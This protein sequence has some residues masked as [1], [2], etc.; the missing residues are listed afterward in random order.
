M[1]F[2]DIIILD[3]I[4]T[5][6]PIISTLI[7]KAHL[8]NQNKLSNPMFIDI[9]NIS[10]LFLLIKYCDYGNAYMVLLVNIPFII[11]VLY[12]RKISSI[13][14]LVAL[15]V[16][17]THVGLNPKLLI[18]EYAV[19]LIIFI[20]LHKKKT[21]A[22]NILLSFVSIKGFFLTIHEYYT[23]NN[24]NILT[25]IQIFICLIVFYGIVILIINII[26][27]VNNT[28]G[29]N[30]SLK[31]LEKEKELKNALFKI[32]HEVKNPI[33]VCKG[34]L[35]MMEYNDLKKV[36]KYN[37]II[38]SELN[39]T[40]DI[41]DKFSKYT[42][43]KINP[44]IM[45]LDYLLTETIENMS[46]IF[47]N[48]NITVNYQSID[49]VFI[50]GDY[51]RLKQAMINILK[52][53][54]EAIEDKGIIDIKLSVSKKYATIVIKDNGC[55]M[56]EEELEKMT[57]MFYSS[58]EKGCGIGAALSKEIINLHKGTIK[59]NS[60]VGEYTKATIRLPI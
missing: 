52:N 53:S 36:K 2:F 31:Q 50:N 23:L 5:L 6:F 22:S 44:D 9:A 38:E 48:N 54:A 12:N 3:I 17:N 42:K 1:S 51:E 28:M 35:Q 14:I 20:L 60:V 40:L 4:L 8:T 15:I 13:I 34:Y 56:S 10:S 7:I 39:R 26:D 37:S 46:S 25:I 21:S 49:E 30:Q 47:K 45:D 58:K 18:G 11:S 19:Y 55:G 43:I 57:E 33:A 41:M 16:F 32:T 59:Y 27:M 24:S 29:L